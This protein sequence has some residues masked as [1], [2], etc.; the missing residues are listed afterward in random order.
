MVEALR[1]AA[2]DALARGAPEA[3]SSYLRR[4]L[5][6]PPG[7]DDRLAVLLDLGRAE[8]MLPVPQDFSALRDAL[9]LA[10]DPSQRAEIA[11]ELAL[12]LYGVLRTRGATRTR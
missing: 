5:T 1:A 8:A 2:R 11:L 9:E 12:A 4:A 7:R 6:E 10:T 3:A